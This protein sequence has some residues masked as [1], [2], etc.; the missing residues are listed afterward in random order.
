MSESV[1]YN[2][3]RLGMPV[4]KINNRLYAHVDNIDKF[5]KKV[6][7]G[8]SIDVKDEPV[9]GLDENEV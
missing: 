7:I 8:Q 2:F 5:L 3:I 9:P 1:F 6:T 4:R